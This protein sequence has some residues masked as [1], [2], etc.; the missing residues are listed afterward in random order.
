[1]TS[2]HSESGKYSYLRDLSTEELER[3]LQQDFIMN[4]DSDTEPDTDYIM[5]IMEVIMS[6]EHTDPD[7]SKQITDAAWKDFQENYHGQSDAYAPVPLPEHNSSTNNQINHLPKA[8]HTHRFVRVALIAVALLG[9]LGGIASATGWLEAILTWTTE[10]FGFVSPRDKGDSDIL[11]DD[12]YADLRNIMAGYTDIAVVPNWAPEGTQME[13]DVRVLEE[14]AKTVINCSYHSSDVLFT[15]TYRIYEVAPQKYFTGYEK[16]VPD[17]LYEHNGIKYQI[18]SNNSKY[19][20]IWYN[21][22]VEGMIQGDL[23]YKDLIK[24]VDSI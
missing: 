18:S 23:T 17:P 7:T 8:K 19:T 1:M 2:N 6:R 22:C 5:A 9:V 13:N 15:V 12:P 16:S 4:G 24:M 14:Q 11:S 3:L 10:T 21:D 20:V